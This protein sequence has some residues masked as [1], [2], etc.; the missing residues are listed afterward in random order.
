MKVEYSKEALRFLEYLYQQGKV[1]VS[2]SMLPAEIEKPSID[3]LHF[4]SKNDHIK[5]ISETGRNFSYQIKD[6]GIAHIEEWHESQ[7]EKQ[8]SDRQTNEALETSKEANQIALIANTIS[9]ES[10]KIAKRASR[11]SLPTFVVSL[12]ALAV[13][14][15]GLLLSFFR[16]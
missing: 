16:Q 9:E 14:I 6:S 7:I 10:N 11:Y 5:I 2:H 12:L 3:L 15:A 8:K 13:S 4:M 1:T